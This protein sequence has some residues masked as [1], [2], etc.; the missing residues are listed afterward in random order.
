MSFRLENVTVSYPNWL[1]ENFSMEI[2]SGKFVSIVG[3]SG[4]GKTT[5]LKIFSGLVM[6]EKGKVFF[7]SKDV[8][9]LP[10]QER[11]IGFVFQG[12]ALFFHMSVFEN[13]AFGLEMR[14]ASGIKEK[15]AAA[16]GLVHLVGFESRK[17]EGLSGGERKRVAIARAIAFNPKLLLLD[18]PLNGLDANLREKMKVMLKNVQQKT[19]ATVVMVTHDIDEAFPLSDLMVVM[20]NA[21]IE[22][23][24]LPEKIFLSPKNKFV[25]DFV[26]DYIIAE[27]KPKGGGKS[28][29]IKAQ[30]DPPSKMGKKKIFISLKKN[31]FRF[32]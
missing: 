11:G 25:K 23:V 6:P 13:V 16:L 26:S 14:K 19:G 32:V 22:Q 18:E 27:A 2:P 3:P 15:V 24:G 28:H 10:P 17:I 4:C 7:D 8:A 12:D 29:L 20:G 1:L 31:N 21:R 5:I 30:F 9:G